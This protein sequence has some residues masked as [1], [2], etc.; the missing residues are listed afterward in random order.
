MS[1]FRFE[2]FGP[3]KKRAKKSETI[4]DKAWRN[5]D[6]TISELFDKKVAYEEIRARITTE[7][8]QPSLR[9]LK[10]H[11]KQL[12]LSRYGQKPPANKGR[13][14]SNNVSPA[15]DDPL[16]VDIVMSEPAYEPN[17]SHKN[18]HPYLQDH[19]TSEPNSP[20]PGPVSAIDN[21]AGTDTIMSMD[22]SILIT[23]G[24][25][26]DANITQINRSSDL[27]QSCCDVVDMSWAFHTPIQDL[28]RGHSN[29]DGSP[30]LRVLAVRLMNIANNKGITVSDCNLAQVIQAT[31]EA[32]ALKE[33]QWTV[34]EE[35]QRK[36]YIDVSRLAI[37]NY[38]VVIYIS[39]EYWEWN[40]HGDSRLALRMRIASPQ[41]L[42][43]E[44]SLTWVVCPDLECSAEL[45]DAIEDEKTDKVRHLLNSGG[46]SIACISANDKFDYL[47]ITNDEVSQELTKY[48]ITQIL[49]LDRASS[50]TL[51][52]LIDFW[53][54]VNN[55]I[56]A[57][58]WSW[59]IS[60][61]NQNDA[62]LEEAF[63]EQ[64]LQCDQVTSIAQRNG[65]RVDDSIIQLSETVMDS[66][67]KAIKLPSSLRLRLLQ[68]FRQLGLDLE[69]RGL[70]GKTPLLKSISMFKENFGIISDF[71]SPGINANIHAKD[72]MGHGYLRIAFGRLGFLGTTPHWL[73]DG[74]FDG[75][76]DFDHQSNLLALLLS[77]DETFRKRA[78]TPKDTPRLTE[79]VFSAVAWDTWTFAFQQLNW[80]MEEMNTYRFKILRR[81]MLSNF[82]APYEAARIQML[83]Q[84][85]VRLGR[86]KVLELEREY[87][88]STERE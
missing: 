51:P 78:I 75:W 86:D 40:G 7:E 43:V 77:K 39:V 37:G 28:L 1:G 30:S 53:D 42:I 18:S 81:P 3:E 19:V 49:E 58:I 52:L 12:G 84:T 27:H 21:S 23:P 67:T 71:L 50:N 22:S 72:D 45:F 9:Q 63:Q 8:F 76:F 15:S 41:D 26:V 64:F 57:K 80:D 85:R 5:H 11:L 62:G 2:H 73:P 17:A 69:I 33:N 14:A 79:L 16:T 74:W 34:V 24:I 32:F 47:E 48:L 88:V 25:T 59:S 20:T 46:I 70:E 68:Y 44:N 38:A 54:V 35:G 55:P 13:T 82:L 61:W 4:S 29:R 66:L 36:W 10:A 60:R 83:G 65:L 6:S 56:I 87:A 31:Q